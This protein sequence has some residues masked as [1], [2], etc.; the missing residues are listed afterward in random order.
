MRSNEERI[1]ALEENIPALRGSLKLHDKATKELS[2]HVQDLGKILK[3]NG[4][5]GVIA[6]V[7]IMWKTS[8]WFLGLTGAGVFFIVVTKVFAGG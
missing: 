7:G 6:Q 3:G 5:I 2:V 1:A 8:L 4:R